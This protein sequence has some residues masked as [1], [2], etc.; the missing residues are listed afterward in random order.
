M[1]ATAAA[2]CGS[3]DEP[4]RDASG[5]AAQA[6]AGRAGGGAPTSGPGSD[7]PPRTA[8]TATAPATPV[9]AVGALQIEPGGIDLGMVRP[10][11]THE[12]S[13]TLRNIGLSPI[14]IAEVKATCACTAPQDIAGSVIDPGG[15]LTFQ[16]TFRA[17]AETGVKTASVALVFEHGGRLQQ[18]RVTFAAQV[19]LPLRA[20]PTHVDAL[21]GVTG[22]DVQVHSVDGRAFRV[23]SAGGEAPVF[24]DGFDPAT[25]E[26]RGAYALRWRLDPRRPDDCEGMKLWWVIETDHPECPILPLY[27]R[28]ECTGARRDEG[29]KLRGWYFKDYL[30]NLGAIRAGTPFETEIELVNS[31]GVPIVEVASLDP[32]A[33]AELVSCTTEGRRTVCRVRFTAAAGHRGLLYGMVDFRSP[34]GSKDIAFVARVLD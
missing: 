28:H 23:L 10:A 22:G 32:A 3:A 4:Q 13:I 27:I 14:R 20:A 16:T 7:A 5:A 33:S 19:V 34:T 2:S 31:A 9:V 6:S 12:A 17:P 11:S 15:T 1:V 21:G 8:V 24:A 26:A 25:K 30:A 18:A 29:Q